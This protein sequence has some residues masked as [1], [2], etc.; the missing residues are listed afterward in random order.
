MTS[1]L[2]TLWGDWWCVRQHFR[3]VLVRF[4]DPDVPI[5]KIIEQRLEWYARDF[6]GP[7]QLRVIDIGDIVDPFIESIM[8]GGVMNDHQLVAGLLGQRR[9]EIRPSSH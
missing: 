6:A 9:R 2:P 1:S 5:V 8:I 4:H 7:D 3:W